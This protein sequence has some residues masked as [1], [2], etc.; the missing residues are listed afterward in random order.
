MGPNDGAARSHNWHC[1]L[2]QEPGAS[3][4][5]DPQEMTDID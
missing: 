4:L 2:S 1:L 3:S 5:P